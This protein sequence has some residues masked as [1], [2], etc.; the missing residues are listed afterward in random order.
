MLPLAVRFANLVSVSDRVTAIKLYMPL[1]ETHR[2]ESSI[3][4]AAFLDHSIAI[5][6]GEETHVLDADHLDEDAL[7]RLIRQYPNEMYSFKQAL[8][9]L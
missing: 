8:G 3:F 6:I 7:L 2:T 9:D 1:I 4:M 5:C